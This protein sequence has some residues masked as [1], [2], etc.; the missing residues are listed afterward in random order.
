M[1]DYD[2]QLS[3]PISFIKKEER[4]VV[5][6][7]TSDNID[8]SGDVVDFQASVSAFGNWQGN[9]REMH[10]PLAVGKAVGYRSVDINH[11]GQN[12]K[13]IEVSA[14]ISKGAEDTWQ[15]VLDGTLS[16]FSIGGRI[17]E[18][19]E[20]EHRMFRGQPVSVVTEYELGELSLV[21]NPANPAANITLVKADDAGLVYAL[22]VEEV[23]CNKS[24]DSVVCITSSGT[25][26]GNVT[27]YSNSSNYTVVDGGCNVT[28]NLQYKE[29]SGNI[30][31]MDNTDNVVVS[32]VD[33]SEDAVAEDTATNV[34]E[35]AISEDISDRISLL[36]RFLTWL[37]DASD[38][39]LGG[40]VDS[41]DEGVEKSA[42]AQD[43][44]ELVA[45]DINDEGEDMN[46]EE[47]TATLSAVI[48]EKLADFAKASKEDIETAVEGRLASAIETVVEKHEDLVSKIEET[49]KEVA[50]RVD[51]INERVE[52]VEDAG[53]IKKSVDETEVEEDEAIAKVAEEDEETSIWN[54]LYLP[55]E[56]I[57][58][59]GYK[60]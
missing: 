47:L 5:G 13:G 34:L 53:A 36:R 29:S 15:K 16:A 18:R 39:E 60:S 44:I 28:K 35:S 6:I 23:E 19:V 31:N 12:F 43:E 46:I 59:L 55:Q 57:K 45:D 21:D 3:F 56:L 4:V 37:T 7:A 50:E 22:D 58:S 38:E 24:G 9:I 30:L 8:K 11:E 33:A 14:Y 17:M 20:D 10:Q 49:N 54:N 27:T 1:H 48:D 26:A 42:E 32:D 41:T 40:L 52:T 51:G 25:T 2:L